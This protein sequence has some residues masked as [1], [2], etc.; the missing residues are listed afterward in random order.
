[1][2]DQAVPRGVK[3]VA[4]FVVDS[5]EN[6][7]VADNGRVCVCVPLYDWHHPH[8][9]ALRNIARAGQASPA[10]SA[11][12]RALRAGPVAV[13]VGGAVVGVSADEVRARG[14]GVPVK[15]TG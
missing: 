1:M 6:R 11:R 15:A 3:E 4:A 14:K 2:A 8:S 7:Q 5:R 10:R 13:E 12:S 9:N